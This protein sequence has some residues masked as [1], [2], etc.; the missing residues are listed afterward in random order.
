MSSIKL[1]GDDEYAMFKEVIRGYLILLNPIAPHIT[2][3]L[4]QILNFGKMILEE[5]WVEHNEE[6]C[7]DDVFE[8]VFQVNGKIRDR[9]EADINISEDD[10]KTQALSRRKSKTVYRRTKTLLK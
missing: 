3:E 4:Y 10:A 1:N 6:Y 5:S 8:L 7:K 2:E 9:V